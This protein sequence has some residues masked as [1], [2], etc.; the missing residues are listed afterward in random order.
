MSQPYDPGYGGGQPQP[1]GAPGQQSP[2]GYPGQQGG[3]PPQQGYPQ[4][5]GYPPQQGGYS[6]SPAPPQQGYPPQYSQQP[7]YPQQPGYGPPPWQPGG[8]AKKGSPLGIGVAIAA[9]LMALG[10]LLPWISVKLNL[11]TS[12]LYG[13]PLSST[14]IS[15]SV[16]GI[17]AAEGKI[18]ML[19]ALVAIGLGIAAMASNGKLGLLAGIP[20]IISILVLLK[21]LG[22]KASYD[23]KVPTFGTG[24]SV[25]VN[26]S[27]GF[28]LTGLMAVAVIG[29]GV[30]CAATSRS[31]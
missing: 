30:I 27:A 6:P 26:L 4:Q 20:A 5:G 8:A 12:N 28:W 29:L 7:A 22:D 13:T 2:G 1:W 23:S 14:N 21:V 25:D 15:R 19:C 11:G 16:S 18:V 31:R 17:K 24:S 10:T 9:A 3:Y